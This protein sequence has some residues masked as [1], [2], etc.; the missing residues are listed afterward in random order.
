MAATERLALGTVQFGLDYG[1]ANDGGRVS[2]DETTRILEV[3]H[4]AGIDTLDTA[5]GYGDSEARLGEIGVAGWRIVSKLPE[6]PDEV[7]DV[8]GWAEACVTGSL[9]RLGVDRL[10][11]LLLHRPAELS[12]EHGI[13]LGAALLEVRQ[14]GLA[15]KIGVSVYGPDELDA[16]WDDRFDL[17]QAPFNVFD[18]RL[19]TSGW[20]G[21]LVEQGVEIHTRSAFLQGLLLMKDWPTYFDR[22]AGWHDAWTAYCAAEDATLLEA[23]LGFVLAPSGIDRVVVGVDTAEQLG[24]I[25]AVDDLQMAPPP[26]TLASDDLDLIKPSRWDLS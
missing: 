23:S 7:D 8:T 21:R 11:G 22:F 6:L 5:I 15:E 1:V 26:D 10:H 17:V 25:L 9:E 13:A 24:E 12:G 18:R 20:L 4:D 19:V 16:V 14:Q 2:V 3:A